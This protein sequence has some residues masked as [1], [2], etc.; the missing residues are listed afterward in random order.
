MMKGGAFIAPPVAKKVVARLKGEEK[1]RKEK[2]KQLSSLT[3]R[4]LEI[5]RLI[6]EGKS[7]KEIAETLFLTQGTV[8]NYISGILQ[9]LELRDRTQIAIF[10]LRNDLV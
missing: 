2:W 4:E 8:K 10:A 1:S 3:D 5:I 6:G 9:K 7:N